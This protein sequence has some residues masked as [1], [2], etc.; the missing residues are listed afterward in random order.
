MA[1]N[2]YNKNDLLQTQII[3]IDENGNGIGKVSGYTLFVKDTVPG[4]IC[5]VKIMKPKK[6]YAFAHLEELIT[7]SE[8]R[9]KPACPVAKACGGCQLQAVTYERQLAYKENKV[10]NNLIRI[11]GFDENFINS[12]WSP[13]VGMENPYHY[14]N[15]AQYPV[16]YNRNGEIV[17]GFYAGRTHSVVEFDDCLLGV[18]ENKEILKTITDW[19]K[20]NRITPYNEETGRGTVR[21]IL[22]RKGFATN[23]IMVCLVVDSDKL[24]ASEELI[25]KLSC[26]ENMTSVSYSVNKGRDNVIMGDN[27]YP[28]WGKPT[29]TDCIGDLRFNISPLSFYQV[30][31]VQTRKMYDTAVEFAGLTGEESVWDLYCGIGTISLSMASRAKNVYGVEIIPQAIEDAKKNAKDNN[32]ENVTFMV[33]KAEEVLP[34]FYEKNVSTGEELC[35]PDVIVVDP[36]RKGCDGKCLETML[37]MSPKRIVYVSCD[38]ATLARDLKILCEGNYIINAVQTFDNFPQTVHVETV[39]LLSKM[40]TT[41]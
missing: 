13:I 10:R 28:V 22:L 4:D 31:P 29:I 2:M 37:Q 9:C 17:Y 12:V 38:S 40:N 8:D 3:D 23:E 41:K 36:P 25:S 5:R 7:P 24:P 34:E 21:H 30:N 39:V 16:G 33:G 11:G 18:T 15:K 6:N 14:R 20:E 32:I 19:M 26:I 1:N 27:Y 35:S